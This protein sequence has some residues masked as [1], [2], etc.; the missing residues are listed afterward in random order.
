MR[1]GDGKD[2]GG[3]EDAIAFEMDN[4]ICP[5][6]EESPPHLCLLDLP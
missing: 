1:D 3:V 6:E 4:F 2:D 5:D